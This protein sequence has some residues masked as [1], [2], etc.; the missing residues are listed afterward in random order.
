MRYFQYLKSLTSKL[1]K[2]IFQFKARTAIFRIE[3]AVFHSFKPGT[4][5]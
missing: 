5:A 2:L 3:K 4:L 1:E